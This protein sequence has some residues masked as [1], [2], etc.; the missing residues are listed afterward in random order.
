MS[1]IAQR[2][3][4]DAMPRTLGDAEPHRL[5][6]NRLPETELAIDH[7]N[8][9]VFEHDFDR[10]IGKHLAGAQPLH[11]RGYP[12]DAVRI[13]ADEVGLDEMNGD[14]LGFV[15]LT[16]GRLENGRDEALQ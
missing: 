10:A 2:D 15:G 6:A 8:R 1:R 7:G 3:D 9:I 5:L 12:D 13:V 14:A 16:A 11:I 4:G